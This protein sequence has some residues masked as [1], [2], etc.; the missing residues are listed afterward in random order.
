M[1]SLIDV[2]Y[3]QLFGFNERWSNFISNVHI[4]IY[5]KEEK[6]MAYP[7]YFNVAGYSDVLFVA[8]NYLYI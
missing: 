8:H 7:M 6:T 1:C 4:S 3:I 2:S 5:C